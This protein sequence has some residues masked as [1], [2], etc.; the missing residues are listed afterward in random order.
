[1]NGSILRE[2]PCVAMPS[3]GGGEVMQSPI[4][5][6]RV[7]RSPANACNRLAKGLSIEFSS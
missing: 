6:F 1:M 7:Y 2:Q 3:V 4:S 5:I